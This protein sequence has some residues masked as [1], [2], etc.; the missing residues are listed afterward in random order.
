MIMRHRMLVQGC[1][2]SV[3][4]GGPI[5]LLLRVLL[6]KTALGTVTVILPH[7]LFIFH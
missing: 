6:L 1:I 2:I 5:E 4:V 7:C 3:K